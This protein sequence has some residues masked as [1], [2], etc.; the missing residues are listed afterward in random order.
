VPRL[1]AAIG[2][3]ESEERAWCERQVE[4]E[5]ETNQVPELGFDL[6]AGEV[7]AVGVSLLDALDGKASHPVN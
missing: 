5:F 3:L 1:L 2:A 4:E 6:V 7:R